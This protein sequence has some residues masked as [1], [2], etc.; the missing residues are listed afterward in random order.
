MKPASKVMCIS[1]EITKIN[2]GKTS[3]DPQNDLEYSEENIFV[4]LVKRRVVLA[5]RKARKPQRNQLLTEKI[6]CNRLSWTQSAYNGVQKVGKKFYFPTKVRVWYKVSNVV[7]SGKVMARR[8][9]K[10]I[11]IQSV[12][13]PKKKMVCG[14]FN[15]QVVGSLYP[16]TG[17]MN[18]SDSMTRINDSTR[19]TIFGDPDSTQITLRK[20]VTRLES[21]FS[22]NNSTRVTF[23]TQWLESQSMTRDSSQY[24]VY[25]ISEF[26]MD[27]PSSFAHKE[28]RGLF[29]S[30]M[31]KIGRNF[32][33]WLSGCAM[34]HF[35]DQVFP[36]CIVEDLKLCFH[37]GVSRTEYIDTLSWF[38]AVFEYRDHGSGP[39]LWP[40]VFSRY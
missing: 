11:I 6:W 40:W 36:T 38:N 23:F 8:S 3:S 17:M 20:I 31:I 18:T 33:F 14:D 22:Q 34:L 24:Y 37:R 12:K 19:V 28:M 4:S 29:G 2:T 35:K 32:L 30:V 21:G 27:K 39:I 1:W 5:G 26:L 7:I 15:F 10:D 25:K 9:Q 16:I 13:H